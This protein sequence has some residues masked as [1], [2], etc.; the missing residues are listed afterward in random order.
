MPSPVIRNPPQSAKFLKRI[1]EELGFGSKYVSLLSCFD[2][3][4]TNNSITNN[5]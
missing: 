5:L 4:K 3:L 1:S 2:A